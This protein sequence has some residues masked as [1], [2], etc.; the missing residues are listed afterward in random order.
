[1]KKFGEGNTP[2]ITGT[3][4]YPDNAPEELDH[5]TNQYMNNI[6][7]ELKNIIESSGQKLKETTLEDLKQAAKAAF[8]LSGK[9]N[10]FTADSSTANNK[11]LKPSDNN[12]VIPDLSLLDGFEFKFINKG[13][14][15][16]NVTVIIEGTG[17]TQALPIVNI[18]GE[19][20]LAGEMQ[21]GNIYAI[22]YSV[23]LNA[24]VFFSTNSY[25]KS[26]A[27]TRFVTKE[28]WLDSAPVGFTMDWEGVSLPSDKWLRYNGA[29]F[30][31]DVYPQLAALNR[32]ANNKLPD[33]S[34][35]YVRYIGNRTDIY[36]QYHLMEDAIQN[37]TG[38]VG[39]LDDAAANMNGPFYTDGRLNVGWFQESSPGYHV[40]FDASRVVRTSDETRPKTIMIRSRIVKAKP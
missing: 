22:R 30:D 29:N 12:I 32:Y 3:I 15:T 35:R 19:Q 40:Y 26:E 2:F 34:D 27:D 18:K 25:S 31:P 23:A 24:F 37:I 7:G 38:K 1:M 33:V 14:N 20:I 4:D 36:I 21:D 28:N 13:T 39:I 5:V 17:Q 16:G 8:I 6:Y 10:Y 9:A 11:I